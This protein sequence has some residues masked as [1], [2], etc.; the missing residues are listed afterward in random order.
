MLIHGDNRL[1]RLDVCLQAAPQFLL[2]DTEVRTLIDRQIEGIHRHW[3][4]VC[5]EAQLA[6]VDAKLLWGR[7][8]LNPDAMT[9]YGSS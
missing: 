7:Q 3:T 4:E 8:F 2:S 5:E 9:S 1:S 6:S